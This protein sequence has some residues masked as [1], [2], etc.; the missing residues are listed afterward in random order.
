MDQPKHIMNDVLIPDK[1]LYTAKTL[2]L[3]P[4]YIRDNHSAAYDALLNMTSLPLTIKHKYTRIN[5]IFKEYIFS[6]ENKKLYMMSIAN[7]YAQYEFDPRG[8]WL[9]IS[10]DAVSQ[11][12]PTMS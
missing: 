9:P 10:P 7:L 4:E 2:M 8:A 3:T 1:S 11:M 6:E 12:L 5:D